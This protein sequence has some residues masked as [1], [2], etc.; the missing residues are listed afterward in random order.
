VGG[1]I[2]YN[3]LNASEYGKMK[4]NELS[5][6]I[7]MI[8]AIVVAMT[9]CGSL[10]KKNEEKTKQAEIS[11]KIEMIRAGITNA[12]IIPLIEKP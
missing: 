12:P 3:R 2:Y 5:W 11:L 4:M 7:I 1:I 9:I 8:G 6:S 10:D